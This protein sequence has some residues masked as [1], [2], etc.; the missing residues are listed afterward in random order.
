MLSDRVMKEHT[1]ADRIF[2]DEAYEKYKAGDPYFIE[3][4]EQLNDVFPMK[5]GS[6]LCTL[7][8]SD[9]I[10]IRDLAASQI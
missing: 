8:R 5:F 3:L 6:P 7:L 2:D 1:M 10:F 9:D 4:Y